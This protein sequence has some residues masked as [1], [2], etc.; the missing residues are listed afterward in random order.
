MDIEGEEL[1]AFQS[2]EKILNTNPSLI[3][4]LHK[5]LDYENLLDYNI[6]KN[7][8]DFKKYTVIAIKHK[9]NSPFLIDSKYDLNLIK[10]LAY[11]EQSKEPLI[12]LNLL[13]K[14]KAI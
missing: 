10:Y 14:P 2:A 7:Y 5:E 11:M 1:N 9:T 3:I 6:I 13:I 4:E 12:D 8:I